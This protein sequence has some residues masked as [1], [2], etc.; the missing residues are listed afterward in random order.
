MQIRNKG[1]E[2][3]EILT[4]D[5]K[6]AL[7][8]QIAIDGFILPGPG[9]YEEKGIFV[10]GIPDDGNTVYTIKA[11]E[12]NICYLGKLSHSLKEEETKEIGDVDILFVPLGQSGGADVKNAITLVSKIDPKIVIP[13]F[14]SDLTLQ[15][16]KK[17]EGIDDG[18]I[19]SLKIKKA[20]L[21]IDERKNVILA[22]SN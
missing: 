2:R 21:P 11:E 13:I 8:A 20:D 18:E 1:E 14:Y 15:E 17:S 4:K 6:I 16:F 22:P 19:D 7:G 10:V 3:I 5:T 12:I 9:E